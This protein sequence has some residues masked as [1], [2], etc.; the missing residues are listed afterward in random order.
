MHYDVDFKKVDLSF[1]LKPIAH[2]P[3]PLLPSS[4]D[5]TGHKQIKLFYR[6]KVMLVRKKDTGALVL[7]TNIDPKLTAYLLYKTPGRIRAHESL[8]CLLRVT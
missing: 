4:T 3:P 5:T 1:L 6:C 7:M 8:F 2:H